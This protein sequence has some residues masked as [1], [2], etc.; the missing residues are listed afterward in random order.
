MKKIAVWGDSVARGI[1]LDEEKNRY[2]MQ[3]DDV[4]ARVAQALGMEIRNFA[5]FGCTVSKGR[6]YMERALDKWKDCDAV[7][8]EFGGNDSNFDWAKIAADPDSEHIPGTPLEQFEKTYTLMLQE[9]Q[10]QG[11]QAVAMTLPPVEVISFFDW[12]TKA[13]LNRENVLRWLGDKQYIYRWHER[14]NSAIL[15]AAQAAGCDCIDIRQEFLNERRLDTVICKDGMHP[16]ARGYSLM[17]RAILRYAQD[18][19]TA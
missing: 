2:I 18:H 6:E 12:V 17:E 11:V 9:I 4:S 5:K 16:N 1:L 3:K 19:L 10:A 14:Y 8:L 7:V 15:R 13:G